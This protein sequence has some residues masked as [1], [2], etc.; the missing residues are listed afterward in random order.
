MKL[1]QLMMIAGLLVMTTAAEA[2]LRLGNPAYGGS[3]CP[4]GTAAV[5]VSPDEQA[6][7][8]LFDQ[9]TVEAGRTTGRRLDRKNC[10]L[11]IPVQVPQGYSVAVFQVDYRGYLAVPRGGAA[12][13]DAEYFWAGSQGPRLSRQFN[14]P[15]NDLFT[16][17]D[18]LLART[19]VW[20]RCGESVNLRVNTSILVQANSAM[21]Q[22][23]G[24]VDSADVSSGVIYHLQWKRCF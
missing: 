23:L 3:G 21:D 5:T 11:T 20:S 14:G 22:T 13:F 1:S 24:Q 6:I 8:V 19:L 2:Q 16:L 17:T 9:Y 12:R 18:E 7:S 4:A 10:N 15:T